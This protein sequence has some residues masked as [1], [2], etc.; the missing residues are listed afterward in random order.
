MTAPAAPEVDQSAVH[1]WRVAFAAESD[2]LSV[3][4]GVLSRD[5]MERVQRF[6]FERDRDRYV[7]GR[8]MLRVILSQYLRIAPA[9]LRFEYGPQ[10]KPMLA[11]D[12]SAL[13]FNVS[14]SA[15]CLLILVGQD[16][17]LGVDVEELQP[18]P[19]QEDI[20]A[21]LFSPAERSL[22]RS[23]PSTETFLAS[24][25][26]K[27]AWIKAI[28]G[29]LSLQLPAM[30][31]SAAIVQG[32]ATLTNPDSDGDRRDTQWSLARVNVR[33]GYAGAICV[34]GRD[35]ELRCFQS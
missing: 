24:W 5:E 18:N 29:G 26:L 28:G 16:R 2:R 27:E 13:C 6:R 7:I 32:T 19:D 23:D 15:D 35:Y 11:V 12:D 1:L 14:H 17:R 8:G 33:P 31:V 22:L 34:E 30:D 21:S 4:D 3:L 10:G 25:T 9:D 20:A